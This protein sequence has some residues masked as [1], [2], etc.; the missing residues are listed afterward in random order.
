MRP[1]S[2]GILLALGLGLLL[3]MAGCGAPVAV[4]QTVNGW[5]TYNVPVLAQGART[6][7]FDPARDCLW[8]VTAVLGGSGGGHTLI[9][10]TRLNVADGS[11]TPTSFGMNGDAFIKGMVALDSRGKVWLGWGRTLASYD[12]DT[13]TVQSWSL[14]SYANVAHADVT[15]SDGRMVA[16]ALGSDGEVWVATKA[17]Q[18][19]FGFNQTAQVW[20]RTVQLPFIANEASRIAEPHPGMLLLS[21]A[22][23]GPQPSAAFAKIDLATGVVTQLPVHAIDYVV[24][25]ND[26]IVY[27]DDVSDV[28]A[29]VDL[30]NNSVTPL[31]P[32][33]PVAHAPDLLLASSGKIWFSMAGFRSV[34]AGKL[35]LA[36]GAVTSYPFPYIDNPGSP[37]PP[38]NCPPVPG[39][40]PPG[41]VFDPQVQ[42]LALDGH[43]N[44][45]VLTSLAGYVNG[46]ATPSGV[47]ELPAG[48]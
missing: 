6:A 3:G 2:A 23:R 39:C 10:L 45:W 44:L 42:A 33:V 27:V 5:Q 36:T 30:S 41:A 29:R 43:A 17:V 4:T 16:L 34:G 48:S 19:L 14:P 32:R 35:D 24:L 15:V 12:P 37:M 1:N 28:A 21:G 20:D 25:P 47:Y 9:S 31:A 11:A 18:A 22:V 46:S 26:Q 13:D 8:I 38:N 7:V 40:V